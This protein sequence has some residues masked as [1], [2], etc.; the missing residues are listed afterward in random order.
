MSRSRAP[1][2][3]PPLTRSSPISCTLRTPRGRDHLEDVVLKGGSPMR[4]RGLIAGVFLCFSL[5]VGCADI[6][7]DPTANTTE[8]LAAEGGSAAVS[9]PGTA[10]DDD[11]PGGA[12]AA[13]ASGT[14]CGPNGLVC[15]ANQVCCARGPLPPQGV[16]Y[17]CLKKG[18][19]CDP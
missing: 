6:P 1:P 13:Q 14:P 5:L 15:G 10:D 8:G 18:A 4:S 7:P 19:V 12:A 16:V 2:T 3:D 17:L 9:V 11:G